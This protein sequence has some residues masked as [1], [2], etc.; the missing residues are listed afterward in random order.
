LLANF[1]VAVVGNLVGGIL[2]VTLTRF[3]QAAGASS[4]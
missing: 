4:A 1:G 2:F 3:G